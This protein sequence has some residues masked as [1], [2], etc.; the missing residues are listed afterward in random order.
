MR[1]WVTTDTH[2]GH[3]KLE[4][5]CNRP[6]GFE[7]LIL[8]H[9]RQMI[10]DDDILIHLGDFCVSED[11]KWHKLFMGISN[12]KKWLIK[13]NYDTK[14]DS[15]YK[16]HGWDFVADS[17]KTKM[18]G[19][20]IMLSHRPSWVKGD[21]DINVHGH[22]HN[23]YHRFLEEEISCIES[24]NYRLVMIENHYCLQTLKD[25]IKGNS[26]INFI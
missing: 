22:L 24:E 7:N 8:K 6:K 16:S 4:E 20:D 2:F 19:F 21:F 23:V 11:T 10:K 18:F 9:Y 5:Y 26:I 14:S 1:Y 13:G 15:W 17:F 3:A 12:C 25:V